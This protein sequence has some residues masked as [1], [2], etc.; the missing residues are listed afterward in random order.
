MSRI[1]EKCATS[2]PMLLDP[3]GRADVFVDAFVPRSGPDSFDRFVGIR[4]AWECNKLRTSRQERLAE[5]PGH[6]AW[7][8]VAFETAA[9]VGRPELYRIRQA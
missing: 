6:S 9:P 1:L 4:L 5:P 8:A 2:S 3:I 7:D